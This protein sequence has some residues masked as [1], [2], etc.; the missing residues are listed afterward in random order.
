MK[1]KTI[2]VFVFVLFVFIPYTGRSQFY[3]EEKKETKEWNWKEHTHFG[4]DL[5]LSFGSITYINVSPAVTLDITDRFSSGVKGTYIFYKNNHFDYRSVV[6]GAGIFGQFKLI[7]NIFIHSEI[8]QLNLDNY[9]EYENI[10]T[11]MLYYVKEGRTWITS[12]FVGGGLKYPIGQKSYVSIMILWNL[13]ETSQSPYSNPIF[14]MSFF[15]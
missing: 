13:N 11:N 9:V 5:G 4:G 6:Y 15:I 7:N 8:E 2:L 14:R 3:T 10:N 12:V 1:T